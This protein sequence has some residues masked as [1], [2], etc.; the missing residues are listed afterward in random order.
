MPVLT[1]AQLQGLASPALDAGTELDPT[2]VD[3][4]PDAPCWG[5]ALFGGDG[6]NAANTPAT[7]FEQAL[8]L[9]ASGALVGLR[10][11]F[12]DWVDTT[13][14]I[15]AATAQA[16]LI[17][18]HFQDALIDLD[19]DAQV[20]CTGA[21]ARL[22]IAAAGLTIS[23]HPTRY[24]IVMASD[25]WYTW[26]HWALGLANNLNAPRNPAVQYTQRDAG[27]NPVNTRCG[28]VWGQHP[29][30]TSVF[31]TE[32]QPGHLSYLQHAVGWP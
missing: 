9:N 13:F 23:A 12:R 31:V 28:H 11:G 8:E 21:F 4:Y 7:I 17:E 20:V 15:P 24:S 14:H 3:P 26:E 1:D 5:W 30:L 29:I 6:G 2:W 25:H 16:D 32:L 27:V 22:C 19:D 10:P 18:R